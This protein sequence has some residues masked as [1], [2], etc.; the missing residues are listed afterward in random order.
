MVENLLSVTRIH[1]DV[2]RVTKSLEPIEEVVSEA[3]YRLKKRLPQASIKVKVPDD[4][5]MIPM[6]AILIEQVIINLLENAVVHAQS[7]EPIQC[8]VTCDR[9]TVAFHI[10]DFGIGIDPDQLDSIFESG[11]LCCGKSSDSSKGMGIGL[12]ICKTIILAHNGTITARNHSEGAEFIFTLPR[13]VNHMNNYKSTI[14]VIEDEK[15]ICNFISTTLSNQNYR[16]LKAYNGVDGLSIITSQ[17][18]DMVLLDLGLPDIDGL[19]IIRRVRSWSSIPILVIS[20]RTQESEKVEALDLGADDYITKPFGTSE[21]MARI[22]T[23]ERHS[24]L[25]SLAGGAP[26]FPCQGSHHRF[27]KAPDLCQRPGSAFDAGGIQNHFPAG[28]QFRKSYD[29]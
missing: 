17:C 9:D 27:C 15:N 18:P 25:P 8:L 5:V 26:Y 2:A 1:D 29:L 11:S 14:L 6:D 10:I 21:L 12:S 4:L 7:R 24:A 20:A 19:T 13:T 28:P 16:V 3:V 22:R 23:A